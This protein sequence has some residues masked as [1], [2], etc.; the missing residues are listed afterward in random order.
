MIYQ[1]NIQS[2]SSDFSVNESSLN[3]VRHV[4]GRRI[5]GVY[6]SSEILKCDHFMNNEIDRLPF[7]CLCSL[8]K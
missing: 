4:V 2:L 6:E 7:S 3:F 1:Q 8:I 5:L